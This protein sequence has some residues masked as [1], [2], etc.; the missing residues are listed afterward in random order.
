MEA[1]QMTSLPGSKLTQVRVLG[2]RASMAAQR[3]RRVIVCSWW[4]ITTMWLALVAQAQV[5][6]VEGCHCQASKTTLS[7]GP[8][9]S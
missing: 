4:I 7:H 1:M 8:D 9:L 5:S 3:D 2:A 6:L